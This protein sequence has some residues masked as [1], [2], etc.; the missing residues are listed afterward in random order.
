VPTGYWGNTPKFMVSYLKSMYGETATR[1]MNSAIMVVPLVLY[2]RRDILGEF[3]MSTS[4]SL[5]LIG[6]F[7]LR[8]VIVFAAQGI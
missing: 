2:R 7:L 5:V 4:A 8:A 6:G 1:K 3:N